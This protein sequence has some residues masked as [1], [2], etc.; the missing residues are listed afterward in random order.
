MWSKETK[1]L[2]ISLAEKGVDLTGKSNASPLN[3]ALAHLTLAEIA[4]S[5][6]GAV[7]SEQI[8]KVL[9]YEKK[10]RQE[11]TPGEL[12]E[13]VL[14]YKRIAELF[15]DQGMKTEA[16]KLLH[17]GLLLANREAADPR[18]A[19]E[20]KTRLGEILKMLP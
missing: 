18:Q 5:A 16:Q 15:L 14:I 8:K 4:N 20:I 2:L 11:G 9:L 13:L 10:I 6:Y 19:G 7:E 17:L 12:R 1:R 3:Q